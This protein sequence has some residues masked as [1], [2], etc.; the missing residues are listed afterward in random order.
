MRYTLLIITL[1]LFFCGPKKE[2][3]RTI[4]QN[5]S[6]KINKTGLV[7]S[8]KSTPEAVLKH[9]SERDD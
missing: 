9:D 4:N 1:F 3:V 2:P 6:S 7:T 8:E 5:D